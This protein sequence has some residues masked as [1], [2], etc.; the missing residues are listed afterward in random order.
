MSTDRL[1]RHVERAGT[2]QGVDASTDLAQY[3]QCVGVGKIPVK[4]GE[5]APW[6]VLGNVP[7]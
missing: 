7:C 1:D 2:I 6:G 5:I 3:D 4:D